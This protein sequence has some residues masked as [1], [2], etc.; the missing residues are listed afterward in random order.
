MP[1]ALSDVSNPRWVDEAQSGVDCTLAHPSRGNIPY[2]CA[3]DAADADTQAL[4]DAIQADQALQ[5]PT[6]SIED[7]VEPTRAQLA[8]AI[9][10]SRAALF[11]RIDAAA[12]IDV[13]EAQ[14]PDWF[15]LQV[16]AAAEAAGG[17]LRAGLERVLRAIQRIQTVSYLNPGPNF[18]NGTPGLAIETVMS[19]VLGLT[20][21]ET[22]DLFIGDV[23]VTIDRADCA[24]PTPVPSLYSRIAALEAA[25]QAL[26]EG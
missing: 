16:Q 3:P 26:I 22:Q 24:I 11:E 4:W 9:T 18:D 14:M 5:T 1:Y 13:D 15:Y 17:P 8:H 2:T 23:T 20:Q 7:Y 6:L 12:S 21:A 25:V 19:T 10:L